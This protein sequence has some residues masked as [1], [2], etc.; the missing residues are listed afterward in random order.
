MSFIE[1]NVRAIGEVA[2]YA[3]REC[4]NL[5]TER[6]DQDQAQ[7]VI[8]ISNMLHSIEFDA[9]R[10]LEMARKRAGGGGAER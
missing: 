4:T 9:E 3:I 2:W 10:A 7:R 1:R 5:L 6:L 8:R